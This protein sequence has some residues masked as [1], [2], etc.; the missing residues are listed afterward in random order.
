MRKLYTNKKVALFSLAAFFISIL[1]VISNFACARAP[2]K[3]T[4]KIAIWGGTD[5]IDIIKR[6]IGEWQ[7]RHPEVIARIEDLT[8]INF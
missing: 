4:I 2:E 3:P 7:K 1:L 5:E 8:Q 6:I